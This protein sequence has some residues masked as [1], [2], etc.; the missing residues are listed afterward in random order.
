MCEKD[1]IWK[2]AE[3]SN[4]MITCDQIVGETKTNQK[5]FNKE[6]TCKT[7]NFYF[8]LAFLLI[9]IALLA[10]IYIYC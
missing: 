10:A 7:Q 9:T 2:P 6:T 4:S 3:G 1:Y 5:S 8:L